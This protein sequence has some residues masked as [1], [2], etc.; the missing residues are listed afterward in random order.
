MSTNNASVIT[1]TTKVNAPVEKAWE[2]W[3]QP[4]HITQ[5]YFASPDWHAP[6]A[7]NDLTVG[8]KLK[9]RMEAKDGSFGFDLEGDYDKVE[10]YKLV[11]YTFADGRKVRV[12][13][14]SDSS[15]TEIEESFDAE[16]QNSQE[17]QKQGWQNILDNFKK[18]I[19]TKK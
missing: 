5:W 12:K 3:N 13:F 16:S 18:Y 7:S 8:G 11:E 17:M 14:K 1:V 10:P 6:L 2:Y 9:I 15:S 4:E 19:E